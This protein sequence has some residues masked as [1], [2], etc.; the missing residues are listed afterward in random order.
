MR[1]RERAVG[2]SVAK[3]RRRRRREPVIDPAVLVALRR[4]LDEMDGREGVDKPTPTFERREQE[5]S[6]GP[7]LRLG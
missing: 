3:T 4:T 6:A 5:P 7:S 2:A 1:P